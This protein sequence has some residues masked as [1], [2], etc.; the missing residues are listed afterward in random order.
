MPAARLWRR[1]SKMLRPWATTPTA[2]SL[3]GQRPGLGG[4][5]LRFLHLGFDFGPHDGGLPLE[6]GLRPRRLL[7]FL[8]GFLVPLGGRDPGGRSHRRSMGGGQVL[9]VAGRILDLLE[10]EAVNHDAELLHLGVASVLDLSA[11]SLAGRRRLR[12]HEPDQIFYTGQ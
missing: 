10:M 7:L 12:G 1:V 4:F 6:L 8:G 9:D 3:L 11:I 5:G 2:I